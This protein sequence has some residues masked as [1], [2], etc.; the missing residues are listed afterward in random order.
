MTSPTM[1]L[2]GRVAVVTG[3]GSG[4]GRASAELMAAAG[5]TVVVADVDLDAA[6]QTVA[7]IEAAGTGAAAAVELDAT[8]LDSIRSLMSFVDTE[9][10]RLNV[11]YSHVGTPGPGGLQ[12]SEADFQ[13]TLDLNVKS[14]FYCTSFAEPLLRRAPGQASVIFTASVSGLVGS[15]FSPLYSLCKGSLV[16]FAKALALSLAPD[17]RVNVIA[18][19]AVETPMLQQFFGRNPD[20]DVAANVRKFVDT[21]VPLDRLCKPEEVAQAAL[22]L[23]SDASSYVTGVTLPVDG[24]YVAR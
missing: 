15:L 17:V 8:S 22:Y 10:G 19:G 11:L 6:K 21:G 12:V 3:S 20:D 13:R 24:G 16:A 7:A 14:A 18:P 4:M 5:A 23:A 1:S 2:E 9:F